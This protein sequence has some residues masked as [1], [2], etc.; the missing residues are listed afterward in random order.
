[1]EEDS[2]INLL[3]ATDLTMVDFRELDND[4]QIGAFAHF[5]SDQLSVFH[6]FENVGQ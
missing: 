1:M 6:C 5:S 4:I 3:C 2:G